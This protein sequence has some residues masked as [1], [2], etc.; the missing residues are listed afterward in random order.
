MEWNKS[1]RDGEVKNAIKTATKL[2]WVGSGSGE[3]THR[4]QMSASALE[5]G[6]NSFRTTD[7]AILTKSIKLRHV[8]HCLAKDNLE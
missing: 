1:K 2:E 3:M 8:L 7:L 6:W 5:W 4:Q